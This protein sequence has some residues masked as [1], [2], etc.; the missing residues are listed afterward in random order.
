MRLFLSAAL[1]FGAFAPGIILVGPAAAQQT[2]APET[3]VPAAAPAERLRT[4]AAI[5]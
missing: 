1:I 2:P 4:G 3:G 5:S